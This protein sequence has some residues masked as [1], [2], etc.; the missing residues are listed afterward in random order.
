MKK[1][2]AESMLALIVT[3]FIIAIMLY[4]TWTITKD[5][6]EKWMYTGVTLIVYLLSLGFILEPSTDEPVYKWGRRK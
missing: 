6:G 2:T 3:T 5:A 1:I 4:T